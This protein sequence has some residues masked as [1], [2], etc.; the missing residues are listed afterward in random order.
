[1]MRKLSMGA[2]R[3]L[4]GSGCE[5]QS[6]PLEASILPDIPNRVFLFDWFGG[7]LDLEMLHFHLKLASFKIWSDF[8]KMKYV[9]HRISLVI[10]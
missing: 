5:T 10:E 6:K 9:Y 3:S 2:A 1:M 8:L 7:S 4:P